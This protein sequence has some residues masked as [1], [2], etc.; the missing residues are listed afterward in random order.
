MIGLALFVAAGVNP[1]QLQ[2][3]L[4][5]WAALERPHRFRPLEYSTRGRPTRRGAVGHVLAVE[6]P[7]LSAL[8]SAATRRV[9]A[10][11]HIYKPLAVALSDGGLQ[12]GSED[13]SEVL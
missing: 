10:R 1:G 2:K 11:M 9:W 13:L 3:I 4:P 8:T 7:R 12:V 5:D 6:L